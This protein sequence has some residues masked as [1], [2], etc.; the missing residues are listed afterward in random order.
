MCF[1]LENFKGSDFASTGMNDAKN[2]SGLNGYASSLFDPTL[3]WSDID[4]L[5]SITKL[6]IIVKGILRGGVCTYKMAWQEY[7]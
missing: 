4:W 3:T 2:G 1:R 5:K 7:I 6:P